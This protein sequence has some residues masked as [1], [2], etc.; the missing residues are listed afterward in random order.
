[1]DNRTFAEL[2]DDLVR[3]INGI[4]DPKTGNNFNVDTSDATDILGIIVNALSQRISEANENL[5]K[6]RNC[7]NPFKASGQELRDVISYRGLT[8]KI[9]TPTR[10][11]ITFTGDTD[12]RATIP[13]GTLITNSAKN[14][15][16]STLSDVIIDEN[17]TAETLAECTEVGAIPLI[18]GELTVFE[19]P[20]YGVSQVTNS[21]N[22]IGTNDETDDEIHKRLFDTTGLNGTGFIDN[23]DSALMNLPGV[24][25]A[26]CFVGKDD[27]KG[28]DYG[29]ICAVVIGGDDEQIAQMLFEKNLFLLSY[30]GDVVK[31][32][33][34]KYLNRDYTIK[35]KRP[36]E[37]KMKLTLVVYEQENLEEIKNQ[38]YPKIQQYI[39]SFPPGSKI[40]GTQIASFANQ[41]NLVNV[42]QF[43]MYNANNDS[44]VFIDIPWN[45]YYS[46]PIEDFHVDAGDI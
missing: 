18:N 22:E 26:R 30:V 2:R 38:I 19:N 44:V 8:P 11:K 13:S 17:G 7:L 21:E 15:H 6:L 4:Q 36:T 37:L 24:T 28:L 46:L 3:E 20:I 10:T 40:Y 42:M 33:K 14:K 23:L 41:L 31:N 12:I 1:M 43:R 39:N 35:F 25:S 45:A 32:V 16:F 27:E 5:L 34:S 9:G 29:Q